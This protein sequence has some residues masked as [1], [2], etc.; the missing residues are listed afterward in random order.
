M[1][2]FFTFFYFDVLII[3]LKLQ[4]FNNHPALIEAPKHQANILGVVVSCCVLC[5]ITLAGSSSGDYVASRAKLNGPV[6]QLWSP[7][8]SLTPVI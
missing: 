8:Q 5:C 3:Q 1:C 2:Y 6:G 7:G 4:S